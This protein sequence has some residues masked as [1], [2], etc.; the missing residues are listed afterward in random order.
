MAALDAIWVLW[1]A[2][3]LLCEGMWTLWEYTRVVCKLALVRPTRLFWD[4]I[5]LPWGRIWLLWECNSML[6]EVTW[7][8][9]GRMP[10]GG[11]QSAA[12]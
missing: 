10:G 12:L 2:V 3:R 1:E 11:S 6:W 9:R 7:L 8:L 4:P 5:W